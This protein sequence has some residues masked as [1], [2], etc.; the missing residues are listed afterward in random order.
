LEC[1][2]LKEEIATVM[3]ERL[4]TPVILVDATARILFS[5]ASADAL[6]KADDGI[7]L[8]DGRLTAGRNFEKRRLQKIIDAATGDVECERV[9]D[10]MLVGRAAGRWP[11]ALLVAPGGTTTTTPNGAP[12]PVALVL[13]HDPGRHVRHPIK[14][15]RA[16]FGW[17]DAEARLAQGL[18]DGHR[19][20][21]IASSRRVS[22]ET[23]RT[24]LRSLFKK[25]GVTR[26]SDLMRILLAL[27]EEPSGS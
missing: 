19:L 14:R 20:A 9:S 13:L 25:T 11:I 4:A 7:L 10:E 3:L 21:E 2:R 26:Q 18:L 23:V 24:Q 6:L 22:V 16:L 15:L 1:T 5:T 17:T 12:V 8:R 27:P